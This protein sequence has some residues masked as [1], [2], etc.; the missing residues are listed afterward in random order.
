MEAILQLKTIH[1]LDLALFQ[2]SAPPLCCCST[3]SADRLQ[4]DGDWKLSRYLGVKLN[5]ADNLSF[6]IAST[7]DVCISIATYNL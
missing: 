6:P 5:L 1:K 4:V 7:A 2:L 3:S